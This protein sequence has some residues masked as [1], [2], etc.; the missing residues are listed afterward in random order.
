MVE[1][2]K[3]LFATIAFTVLKAACLTDAA[4]MSKCSV[5]IVNPNAGLCKGKTFTYK[6]CTADRPWYRMTEDE[7]KNKTISLISDLESY[8][9]DNCTSEITATC[10]SFLPTTS[11]TARPFNHSERQKCHFSVFY[12]R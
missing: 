2:R 4:M 11:V 8:S 1:H 9:W 7:L 6:I 12:L 10:K 3:L 5:A